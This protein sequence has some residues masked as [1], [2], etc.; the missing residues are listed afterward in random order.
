MN[1][2][3]INYN[4]YKNFIEVCETKSFSKAAENMH[5]TQPNVGSAIKE[6]EAQLNTKLF[7]THTRGVELTNAAKELYEIVQ[8]ALLQLNRC[9]DVVNEM[10]EYKTGQINFSC[11][12]HIACFVLLKFICDFN[13]Q[14]PNI[15]L[16][17]YSAGKNVTTDMLAKRNIE[18]IIDVLPIDNGPLETVNLLEL[19]YSFYT[20]KG[21]LEKNELN[22]IISKSDLEKY[23]II[24]PA[25]TSRTMRSLMKKLKIDLNVMIEATTSE[26]GYNMVL[27]GCGIGH[28][29][30]MFLD[31]NYRKD[32]IVKLKLKDAELPSAS[33]VYACYENSVSKTGKMFLKGLKEYCQ[34]LG[35]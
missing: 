8:P 32:E 19:P 9:E 33:L 21:F 14:Y 5:C 28:T 17:I 34:K 7:V 12:S 16:R 15:K 22:Q 10:N 4:L 31:G 3:N 6:L 18:F 30:E 27:N 11:Q 13:K 1:F 23:P 24:V 2:S 29:L 20:S 26:L 25:K 35:A